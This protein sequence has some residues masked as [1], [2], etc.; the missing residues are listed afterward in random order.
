LERADAIN[1][2][3]ELINQR[4]VQLLFVT[5]LR[6]EHGKYD[7]LIRGDCDTIELRAFLAGKN[8]VLFEDK[9]KKTFRIY[10]P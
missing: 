8:L 6:N 5:L 2:L 7:V 4:I 3:K 10:R 1:V 9:E